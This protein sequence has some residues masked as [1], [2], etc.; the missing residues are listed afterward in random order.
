MNSTANASS[1]ANPLA[2]PEQTPHPGKELLHRYRAIWQAAWS[3][4][5]EMVG[6]KRLADQTAFLPAALSL[7][8]TPL[9]PAPRRTAWA[10]CA[11]FLIALLWSIFGKI[12][13]VAVAHGRIIV[14]ERSKTVQPL[15]AGVIR[16][17]HVKDGDQVV[18]G[19]VLIELDPT[20]ASA[21]SA[22]V[23]EQLAAAQ[24]ELIRTTALLEAL[25]QN[26]TPA[27]SNAKAVPLTVAQQLQ[28]EWQDITAK[29][30]KINSEQ[31]RRQAEMAT[32]NATIAKLEATLPLAKQREA[33]VK[34]LAEQGFMSSHLPQDRARERIELERD[35]TTQR[36]RK[37]EAQ[38]A[39]FEATQAQAA[40]RAETQRLLSE[41]QAQAHTK[42]EQLGQEQNKAQARTRLTQLTAPTSGTVQ[43]LAVHTTGGVVT[44]AQVL[45]VIV[46][47]D[48]EVTAEVVVDNKDIGFVQ[49]G[50]TS[51]IKLETFPFTRYGT[52]DAQVKTVAADAV[53]DEKRGAIFPALLTLKSSTLN[54]D[55]KRVNLAPG[56]NL[57]AEI[58]TGQRRIISY[59]FNP[60]HKALDE[61][62]GER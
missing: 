19:Q 55:G 29:L 4:R 13:I 28:T 30:A 8:E 31:A 38:A 48:A 16:Q 49:A 2:K 11:L 23:G 43:Q 33:D 36:A 14:S 27:L 15:E 51:T 6:P 18:A 47:K 25:R 7:Q 41:R 32:V 26:K 17:V 50:Q 21:D 46:P 37:Q 1:Q 5:H 45:M 53:N 10:L 58:K 22:S 52:V 9:H 44:T 40:Y 35:L 34:G 54:V 20:N 57:S 56:M 3:A 12:D 61:S 39:A 59:L 42:Q 60:V 62:L 24:S